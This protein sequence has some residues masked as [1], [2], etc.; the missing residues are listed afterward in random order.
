MLKSLLQWSTVVSLVSS[1][2]YNA[3]YRSLV[4]V[5]HFQVLVYRIEISYKNQPD[6]G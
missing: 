4:E 6:V 2:H 3:E 5:K 1:H